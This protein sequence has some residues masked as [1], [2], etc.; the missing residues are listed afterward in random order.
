VATDT[1]PTDNISA[2][3]VDK[4]GQLWVGFA[5]CCNVGAGKLAVADDG[6]IISY[7]QATEGFVQTITTDDQNNIWF[8]TFYDGLLRFDGQQLQNVTV[9][10]GLG[11]V[12]ATC[13]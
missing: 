6:S 12:P 11:R 4:L 1:L 10:D 2:L 3:A 13:G 7:E 9:A 8:G 5:Q